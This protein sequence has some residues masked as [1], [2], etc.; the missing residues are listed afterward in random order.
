MARG[1]TL[2]GETLA[3]AEKMLR[4]VTTI[5]EENGVE[6]FLDA[7]TLLGIV[8]ENRLLPWDDDLDLAITEEFESK[9][10]SLKL[11]FALRG[12][13]LRVKRYQRD[14]GPFKAGA[15]RILKVA[16]RKF[17]LFNDLRLMDILVKHPL[18]DD[19]CWTEGS[20]KIVLKSIP[21]KFYDESK[22][23]EFQG[24]SYTAPKDTDNFL[25]HHYGEDWRTPVTEWNFLEDDRCPKEALT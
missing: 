11:C 13:R 10:L 2:E 17:F 3:I 21:R 23:I 8:R 6:Y 25:V 20:K 7:G 24:K 12:Y 22:E 19:L 4:E 14:V 18:G 5:L 16:T 1:H 9:I 15:V